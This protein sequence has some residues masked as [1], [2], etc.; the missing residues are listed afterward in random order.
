MGWGGMHRRLYN[1]FV[2]DFMEKL[3]PLNKF[4]TYCAIAM[5]FA[6]FTF[7]YNFFTTIFSKNKPQAENNPWKVGT[8]EWDMPSPAPYYNF[9]E[10]PHVKCGP[11]EL[12]NPNLPDGKDFQYQT[13]VLVKA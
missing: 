6:Q 3:M 9:K 5:G 8:L 13:E 4:T 11:H 10:I 12:G 7:L 2:Y 1:P